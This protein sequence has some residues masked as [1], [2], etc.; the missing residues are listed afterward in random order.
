MKT[1]YCIWCNEETPYCV[2]LDN[3]HLVHKNDIGFFVTELRATCTK[4]GFDV[5]VPEVNDRNAERR[6]KAYFR[7]LKRRKLNSRF[8][9]EY[10]FGGYYG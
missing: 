5:D 10:Y 7:S 3:K 6:E 8:K 9:K 1:A 4:C 2:D